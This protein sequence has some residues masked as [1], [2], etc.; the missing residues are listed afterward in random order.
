MY[1]VVNLLCYSQRPLDRLSV[2][3]ESYY[4]LRGQPL[5]ARGGVE[6]GIRPWAPLE[7]RMTR[8]LGGQTVAVSHH[9][10]KWAGWRVR[11]RDHL[12]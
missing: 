8:Y 3:H 6:L 12:Y 9:A 11:I 2:E 5:A 1:P 10:G 4:L 7:R